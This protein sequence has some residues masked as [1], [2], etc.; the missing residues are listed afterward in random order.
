MKAAGKGT[1]KLEGGVC[2]LDTAL[3]LVSDSRYGSAAALQAVMV[4]FTALVKPAWIVRVPLELTVELEAR[5]FSL[6]S[7]LSKSI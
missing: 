1:K 6:N 4:G 5:G 2:C 3:N 7:L